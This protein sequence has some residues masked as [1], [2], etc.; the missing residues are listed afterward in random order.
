MNNIGVLYYF[1][2]FTFIFLFLSLTL[3]GFGQFVNFGQDR[4]SLRWKQINTRDFQIIYP[5]F[6][7]RNAQK[8]ANIYQSLYQHA[9]TLQLKPKKISM[10]VHPDGGVSNGNVALVPRKSE[11]YTMP[12]QEPTDSWLEHLCVHEF[13]HVVQLDKVN[14][15]FTKGAGYLFGELFPI[16]V[17]GVYVPMWFMEGDAVCFESTVGQLGRGRSPE[18]LNKMKAQVVDKGIYNFSKAVLGS[19]KDF[20]PN[21]YIMGYF[22][23]AQSR[24]NY[25]SDIWGKALE[26]CGRRPWGITPFSK[27]L[28]I[29]MQRSTNSQTKRILYQD[30]FSE[31]RQRWIEETAQVENT[32]DT[33]TTR[34]KCYTDY[35]YPTPISSEGLIAYKKGLRETGAF[36]L[37]QGKQEKL[38]TRTGTP[39]DYKFAYNNGKIIWSEYL[40]HV[41]WEQGGRMR[42]S[43]YDLNSGKYKRLRGTT[44][45]F[46]PF[47]TDNGWGFVEVNRQNQ[48]SIVLTDSTLK[49][50]KWRLPAQENE[51]FIHP[52]Y[53]QGNIFTVVQSPQGLHL[54]SIDIQTQTR[55]KLTEDVFY[56]IDNPIIQDST[57]I[58]RASY[59]GNNAFYQ[60]SQNK[61]SHILDSRYGIRFPALQTDSNRLYFSFYT[62][63][64]YKPGRA[65]YRNVSHQAVEYARY[66]LADSI[67]QQENWTSS[68]TADSVYTTRKYR[69][70]PHLFNIHSW[71][72][73][74]ID[75]YDMDVNIGAVVYSQNKL[76]T[77]SFTAGYILK[78]GYP[79]GTWLL[80]ASYRGWWPILDV[81][82]K[83]GKDD[84]YT[85]MEARHLATDSVHSL[86]VH[87]KVRHSDADIA[88]L[89]PFNLSRKQYSRRIQPYIRYQWESF[90]NQ[91]PDQIFSYKQVE[92][93][94][95]LYPAN[96]REF[97]I[98]QSPL[99]YHLL[100]YGLTFSNQTRMTEQ[101]IN[102][103]WGQV[104]SIGYTHDLESG[105]N[106]GYQWWYDC[107]FYF[108]GIL[109]NHSID[110]YH[111]FQHMSD[112]NRN[113]SRKIL[114]PRGIHLYGY[115]L[116][117]LRC[118]YHF[119]ICF[120]DQPIGSLLY[121]K[122]LK[123]GLFYDL[124]YNRHQLKSSH[125]SSYGIELSTDTHFFQ[126]TYPVHLGVRSGYE[127]RS[128]KMF[129]ELIFSIG[130]SI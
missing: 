58:Y 130:L 2:K 75:L 29:S 118:S 80:K 25:G 110:L 20:V 33:L 114:S 43:S 47:K 129:A 66:P 32:F 85:T 1:R 56:E 97:D 68:L 95:W 36:V 14:Q 127:T 111:G 108:P 3:K 63:D 6:F 9:N 87:N 125:Y 122:T 11:L 128:K 51:L 40:P 101:E 126:L 59:N 99:F 35:F 42:L 49:T 26:R 41:R 73:L 21:R 48:A 115:E 102:P 119:P 92:N 19:C 103:R 44:N 86:F 109:T 55:K 83:S 79:H 76:S 22:M 70:F 113:Y 37:L 77:L 12:G 96:P 74:C 50:E 30:N 65:D 13:R 52:T 64:G 46:A 91:Q 107:K 93:Q 45:Q 69:K 16:A 124:G 71:G 84:Y 72:P 104:L 34:N 121:F 54:E 82:L 105:L 57:V 61:I 62:S 24:I 100:E 18:F 90:H 23:T 53:A 117:S 17:V 15:G 78:S 7:E 39:E 120:P 98:H 8:M 94:L 38:L 67:K 60:L 112:K 10:I 116:A 88:L 5:D 28:S 27:S 106:L 123:G 31:L 89:F 4:A 81:E